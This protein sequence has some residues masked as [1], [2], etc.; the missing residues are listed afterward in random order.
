MMWQQTDSLLNKVVYNDVG[1]DQHLKV[2]QH[3]KVVWNVG[4]G[5]LEKC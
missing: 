1:D 4:H 2:N 3:V 5:R